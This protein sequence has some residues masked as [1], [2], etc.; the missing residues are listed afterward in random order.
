MAQNNKNAIDRI[1]RRRD[2]NRRDEVASNTSPK[3]FRKNKDIQQKVVADT[4]EEY[5]KWKKCSRCGQIKLA[6]NRFFS[7]NSTS[8]DGFYSICKCCRNK[9]KG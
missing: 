1:N 9:K 6:N 3:F 7:K 5:G 4:N 2:I 8:K